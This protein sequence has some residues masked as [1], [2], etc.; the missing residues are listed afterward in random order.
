ML[1]TTYTLD[2][3]GELTQLT[4]PDSSYLYLY[5][6]H[7]HRLTDITDA[8]NNEIEYTLDALGDKTE[9]DTYNTSDVLERQHSATFDALGRMLTDVGGVGQ[10]TTFTYDPNGNA[11]P[12]PT[13]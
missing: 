1:T 11:S 5:Y 12:S 3:A 6:D 10:T 7:A 4:L 9:I 13:R 8:D 2:P